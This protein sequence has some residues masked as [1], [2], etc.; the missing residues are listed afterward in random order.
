MLWTIEEGS[1]PMRRFDSGATRDENTTKL[2]Y[3]G[4]LSPVALHEFA[5]YMQRH[6]VQADGTLRASDNWKKGIPIKCYAESFYR[7]AFELWY[8]IECGGA[9]RDKITDK[10][11]AVFFNLQGWLHEHTLERPYD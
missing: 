9:E 10:L 7:H 4:F 6:R 11:C 1:M 5:K 3:K 8:M 2:D